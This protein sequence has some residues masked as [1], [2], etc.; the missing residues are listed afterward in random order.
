[1]D[2][3]SFFCGASS[4]KS[5]GHSSSSDTEDKIDSNQSDTEFL[6]PSPAKKRLIVHE[7][8][9]KE[10]LTTHEKSKKIAASSRKYNKKW[11]ES[12]NWLMFDKISKELFVRFAGREEFL[13]KE[14]EEHGSQNLSRTGRRQ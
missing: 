11:E 5:P 4:S 13:F 14:Q 7:K 3:R 2:I 6:E 8:H 1:M 10:R 12:F 9:A